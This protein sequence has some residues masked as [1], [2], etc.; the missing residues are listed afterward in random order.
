V[1][2]EADAG[3]DLVHELFD[4]G[5]GG[6]VFG[7]H[8]YRGARARDAAAE[9]ACS[10]TSRFYFVEAGDEDAANGFDDDVFQTAADEVIVLFHEAGDESR[11][12]APLADGVF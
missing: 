4:A 9:G 1:V 7:K 10:L 6:G 8:K 3:I 12:I 2:I 11:D 5:G